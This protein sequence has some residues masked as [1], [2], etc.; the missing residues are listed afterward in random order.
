MGQSNVE[1]EV[2]VVSK[3]I[4][5]IQS[6]FGVTSSTISHR[7]TNLHGPVEGREQD[8]TNSINDEADYSVISKTL[9]SRYHVPFQ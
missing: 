2:L 1:N 8:N 7:G 5:D 4:P 3:K 6:R 9:D